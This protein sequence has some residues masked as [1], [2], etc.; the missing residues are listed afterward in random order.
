MY[1]DG[2]KLLLTMNPMEKLKNTTNKTSE[3]MTY[4]IDNK[5]F[6]CQHNK[7][8]A[9]TDRRG[10]WISE[11]LYRQITSIVNNDSPNCITPEDGEDL[12][13][14]KWTNFKIDYDQYHC[15]GFSQSLCLEIENKRKSLVKL[16]NLVNKL[17][18]N[19]K[20]LD[21][22]C[23]VSTDFISKLTDFFHNHW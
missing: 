4:L 9:L 22:C 23:G 10:K 21:K 15:S 1:A 8:H 13:H 7:L 19:N 12:L 11:T 6:Q 2:L 14:Q 3:N 18:M 5:K 16:Y 20:F 17:N